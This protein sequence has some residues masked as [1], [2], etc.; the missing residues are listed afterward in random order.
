[1]ISRRRFLVAFGSA[2]AGVVLSGNQLERALAAMHGVEKENQGVRW[3]MIVDTRKCEGDCT[4]CIDACK[5]EYNIPDIEG[6]DRIWWITHTKFHNAFPEQTH[7]RLGELEEL[8]V[9]IL[10][11]HC[12]NPACVK[13]CPTQ[14]TW[15]RDDGI[16]S[17]DWHRCI[18]CRY[19]MA[20][21]PYGSRSF[22]WKDPRPYLKDGITN[23]DF[24]TRMKGVVEKCI[25]CYPRIDSGN[26]V[27]ACVE[28]CENDALIFGDLNKF[29]S[30][31]SKILDK[32]FTLRRKPSTG[33]NPTVYYILPWGEE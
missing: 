7:G 18:G 17:M 1:M 23:P 24:P 3:G 11:N 22:N 27:P 16:V 32:E 13:V 2:M 5:K 6:D 4:D 14:A 12:E 30:E 19:C 25:F 31:I 28:A 26:P 15:Q 9:L 21:C 10:C 33:L 29:D 8:E 20:A